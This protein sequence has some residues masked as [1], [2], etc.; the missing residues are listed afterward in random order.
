VDAGV[1]R[2]LLLDRGGDAAVDAAVDAV[3]HLVRAR[4]DRQAALDVVVEVAPGAGELA[5]RGAVLREAGA[6]GVRAWVPWGGRPDADWVRRGRGW[7]A[8]VNRSAPEGLDVMEAMDGAGPG[9]PRRGG[10]CPVGGLRLELRPDGTACHCPNLPGAVGTAP[11]RADG[12][13]AL[14]TGLA[15]QRE[16]IRACA[17]WCGHAELLGR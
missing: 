6:D 12:L 13:D 3:R 17:R 15:A 16:G 11:L 4:R 9:A 1:R 7:I 5:E 10:H 8:S 14:L 2:V